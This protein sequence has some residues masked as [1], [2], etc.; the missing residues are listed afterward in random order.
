MFLLFSLFACNNDATPT[1]FSISCEAIS[2]HFVTQATPSVDD[3]TGFWECYQESNGC[4][5]ESCTWQSS[6]L[7]DYVLSE[8][9]TQ[10]QSCQ[11]D[12]VQVQECTSESNTGSVQ[13]DCSTEGEIHITV[14]GLPDHNFENYA[15]SG[16]LP[17]LLGSQA[18]NMEYSFTTNPTYNDDADIFDVGGGTYSVAINGVSMFNQF[19][20]IGTVA[21]TDEIVDDCGGHPANGTYHYH[22]LPYC[23]A[24]ASSA[25]LG[26]TAEHS[27]IMG[28]SLDGYPILGPY[29]YTDPTDSSSS[30]VRLESCYV[31]DS[32]DDDTNASCYTFDQEG[33]NNGTCHLDKCNGRITSVPSNLQDALGSEI[34]SYY[35]TIDNDGLPAFPYQ[36]YCYR[37]ESQS[38]SMSTPPSGGPPP[39]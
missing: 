2:N 17:P 34:Y 12:G 15:L 11:I 19:T 33:Y 8:D 14:H 16:M 35:M 39:Q 27:G 25:A 24:L 13:I 4:E 3:W 32:C 5:G 26:S 7:P 18:S 22:A 38:G 9:C 1:D 36:P 23:G 37:G 6:E 30:I 31:M 20:G 21:V 10:A 29:G 28:L